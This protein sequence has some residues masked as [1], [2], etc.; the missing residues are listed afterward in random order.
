MQ[1]GYDVYY[2]WYN[3]H[4]EEKRRCDD[5]DDLLLKFPTPHG[6]NIPQNQFDI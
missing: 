4:S 3:W 6:T 1:M 5:E 2:I